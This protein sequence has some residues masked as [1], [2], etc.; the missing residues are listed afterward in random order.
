MPRIVAMVE[1]GVDMVVVVVGLWYFGG[2]ATLSNAGY[3]SGEK[4]NEPGRKIPTDVK[5]DS[6]YTHDTLL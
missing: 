2:W 3:L 1:G 4:G 6:G 5:L